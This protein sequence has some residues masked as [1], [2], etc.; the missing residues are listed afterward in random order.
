LNKTQRDEGMF[1]TRVLLVDDDEMSRD[2]LSRRLIRR[3]FEVIFAVDG[4]QGVEAARREKPDIILMDMGL[5]V[6]DGWEATRCIKSD[7][8]TRGVSVIGLSAR[9]MSGDRDK[10]IE[11]GC[12]DY[13]IKPIEFDRL[14]GKIELLL[15]LAKIQV[16]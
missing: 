15:G 16:R 12:D 2:M 5:P 3:G 6:M 7:D 4:K 11:A 8:A 10:A 1:M 14:I 9:T 13:D